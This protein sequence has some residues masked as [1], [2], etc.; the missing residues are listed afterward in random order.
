MA[1]VHAR[2]GNSVCIEMELK[3]AAGMEAL[4]KEALKHTRSGQSAAALKRLHDSS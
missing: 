1:H 2:L 4:E 3:M